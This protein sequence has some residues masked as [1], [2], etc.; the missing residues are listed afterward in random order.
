M[1]VTAGDGRPDGPRDRAPAWP[2]VVAAALIVAALLAAF[3]RAL[4]QLYSLNFSTEGPGPTAALVVLLVSGWTIPLAARREAAERGART[5]GG[6]AGA[7]PGRGG[8]GSLP[9]RLSR[10]GGLAAVGGLAVAASF[11]PSA[12][13]AVVAG[14]AAFP[15]LTP[16]L[17]ALVQ[18]LGEATGTGLALGVLVHQAL[19][20]AGGGAPLAAT[21]AGTVL[22]LVLA[23]SLP[24]AWAGLRLRGG[25]PRLPRRGIR[26]D[27]AVLLAVLVAEAAFL[28][29]AD[30]P[31]TW[32]DS[33]R[34]VVALASA[35]GLAAGGLLAGGGVGAAGR[36]P[37]AWAGI[38][39]L[40]AV[41]VAGPGLLAGLAV[42]PLQLALV[43]LVAASAR[44]GPGWTARG[45]GVDA[46]LAQ[47]VAVALL[48]LLVWAGN[49][50][51][52]PGGAAVRGQAALLLGLLLAWPGAAALSRD[53]RDGGWPT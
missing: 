48:L 17:V 46:A 51:F 2:P 12:P 42:L 26:S 27:P 24:A 49:W 25:A 53:D 20:A 4:P 34:L 16:P 7:R 18:D 21:G 1:T 9:W 23:A 41:D 47:G 8:D 19:R 15:L 50:A 52:V 29:S 37:W 28:A 40:A 45:V 14:L 44:P 43:L 11:L 31:A 10:T 38:A 3:H 36:W 39:A 5:E 22:A 30:A 32:H 35:A 33:S 6:G 13:A